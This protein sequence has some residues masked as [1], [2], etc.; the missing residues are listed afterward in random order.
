M[1]MLDAKNI[2]RATAGYRIHFEKRDG[3]L[4]MSDYFP[5]SDEPPIADID[6]AWNVAEQWAA[7]D[8]ERFVNV[9]V[10]HALD[11]TPVHDYGQRRLNT[12]PKKRSESAQ[13]D[14]AVAGTD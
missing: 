13:T 2:M 10:V 4:L 3:G 6:D 8:P 5:E 1:R 11:W 14:P 7:V 12:H 9:Y